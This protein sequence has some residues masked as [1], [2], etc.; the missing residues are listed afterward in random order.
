MRAPIRLAPVTI[1][2][3]IALMTPVARAVDNGTAATVRP[4]CPN[5][6]FTYPSGLRATRRVVL[7]GSVSCA[8]AMRVINVWRTH[9]CR[10]RICPPQAGGWICSYLSAVEVKDS[11]GLLTGGCYRPPFHRGPSFDIDKLSA[12]ASAAGMLSGTAL[13][14]KVSAKRTP[15]FGRTATVRT[16][17]GAVLI[18]TPSSANFAPLTSLASVPMG[19]TID[20]TNGTVLLTSATP[21]GGSQSGRFYSGIFKI[22]QSKTRSRLKRHHVSGVTLL[23]LVGGLPAGCATSRTRVFATGAAASA[24]R[25]WGNA[26]GNFRTQGRYAS[27][28][29]RGTKWLTEDTCAGTLVNVARGVV[30]VEDLRTHKTVLVPAGKSLLSKSGAKGATELTARLATGKVNCGLTFRQTE[31]KTVHFLLCV[32]LLPQPNGTNPLRQWA[33]LEADGHTTTC[34]DKVSE[35]A[36]CLASVNGAARGVP[37]YGANV[38]PPGT[39]LALGI[40]VCKVSE[41]GVECTIPATGKGFSIAPNLATVI[42]G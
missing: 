40:Y 1:A 25:L 6:A 11:G 29:V 37:G 39:T 13:V 28:T 22:T 26:H 42:G 12:R 20:S 18:K 33:K 2:L 24:R 41:A 8:E 17:S 34:V 32:G 23:S 35:L 7:H 15:V 4:S 16:V 21:S 14:A 31:R 5:V 38:V 19:T 36:N 30:A 10:S 9:P 3:A 27:A